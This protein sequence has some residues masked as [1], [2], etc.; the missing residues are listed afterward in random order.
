MHPRH[1][2]TG[3][4]CSRRCNSSVIILTNSM[5]QSPSWEASRSS[6]SQEIPR[7]LWNPKVHYRTHKSPHEISVINTNTL[8]AL[9]FILSK[10]QTLFWRR[11][12]HCIIEGQSHSIKQESNW[13]HLMKGRAWL[14]W[15]WYVI[16]QPCGLTLICQ[17]QLR[18]I[19]TIILK[20]VITNIET[21][22]YKVFTVRK[23]HLC[24]FFNT[25]KSGRWVL[26]FQRNKMLI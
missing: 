13:S 17:H 24:F 15:E 4:S 14:S 3:T 2:S 12:I 20:W 7:V 18:K 16:C 5:E 21:L 19:R 1:L 22:L 26:M 11:K 23:V 8:K 10:I 25:M 9:K 6:A